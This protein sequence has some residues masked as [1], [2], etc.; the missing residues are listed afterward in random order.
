MSAHVVVM[1]IATTPL[2]AAVV[3]RLDE[4][5]RDRMSAGAALV[6]WVVGCMIAAALV[7]AFDRPPGALSWSAVAAG[8]VWI[9]GTWA[10]RPVTAAVKR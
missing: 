7:Y 10:F 8:W 9:M 2:L 6:T 1:L 3:C 5:N 4:F